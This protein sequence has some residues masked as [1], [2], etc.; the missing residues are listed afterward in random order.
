MDVLTGAPQERRLKYVVRRLTKVRGLW[1]PVV[2]IVM[3]S[4]REAQWL[5]VPE[6][7]SLWS[8][9][10]PTEEAAPLLAAVDAETV[11]ARLETF[12]ALNP[13]LHAKLIDE[14]MHPA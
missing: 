9:L 2:Y 7:H 13:R 10:A 12:A 4:L 5:A 1:T 8:P 14:L 6:R 11:K 3:Q